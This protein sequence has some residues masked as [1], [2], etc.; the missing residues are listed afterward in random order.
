MVNIAFDRV[1]RLYRAWGGD[2]RLQARGKIVFIFER[3]RRCRRYRIG[4]RW[5]PGSFPSGARA[6]SIPWVIESENDDMEKVF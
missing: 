5:N 3:V 4:R 2:K 1:V 6:R